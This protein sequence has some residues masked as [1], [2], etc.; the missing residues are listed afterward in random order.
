MNGDISFSTEGMVVHLSGEIK[1]KHLTEL[2]N[3]IRNFNQK[4][5]PLFIEQTDYFYEISDELRLNTTFQNISSVLIK[6]YEEHHTRHTRVDNIVEISQDSGR[7]ETEL[8]I[9][10]VDLDKKIKTVLDGIRIKNVGF[11]IIH[12]S[13][14]MSKEEHKKIHES[15]MQKF[16]R[17]PTE[18]II[19][20]RSTKRT[21]I[22]IIFFG[23]EIVKNESF[24]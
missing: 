18:N 13:G 9:N 10:Q 14:L 7:L 16:L 11:A 6:D 5:D 4:T 21:L 17:I 23:E 12:T 19:T 24:F 22:E 8:K 20:K 3:L 15:I 1:T 2:N